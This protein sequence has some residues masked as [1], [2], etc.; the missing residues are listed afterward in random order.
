[1]QQ[2]AYSALFEKNLAGS[3]DQQSAYRVTARKKE[4]KVVGVE[5]SFFGMHTGTSSRV[6]YACYHDRH[7]F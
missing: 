2:C 1:M 6:T 7:A 3:T 4:E 5:L